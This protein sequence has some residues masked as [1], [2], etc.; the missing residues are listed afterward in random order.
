LAHEETRDIVIERPAQ[1]CASRGAVVTRTVSAAETG[2]RAE[3][4]HLAHEK[5][6]AQLRMH[7][8]DVATELLTI[9]GYLTAADG[10]LAESDR[11]LSWHERLLLKAMERLE[12]ID[13]YL[14][15]R[16]AFFVAGKDRGYDFFGSDLEV[17]AA[18]L[19]TCRA[20]TRVV[21]TLLSGRLPSECEAAWMGDAALR[22]Y[23]ALETT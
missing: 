15:G 20:T 22:I 4:S 6:L 18:A 12:L 14:R 21:E 23:T 3:Q 16:V 19:D 7:L 10:P 17:A 8:P 9:V 1:T 13:G 5:A 2:G 11:L